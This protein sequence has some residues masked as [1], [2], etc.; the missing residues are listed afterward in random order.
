LTPEGPVMLFTK[1]LSRTSIP[2]SLVES[3]AKAA[4]MAVARVCVPYMFTLL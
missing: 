4:E 3:A 2:L 1:T